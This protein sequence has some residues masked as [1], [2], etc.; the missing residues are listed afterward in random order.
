MTIFKNP[1]FLTCCILFWINQFLERVLEIYI[2][3]MHAY[4]DDLLAMP[5]V[6]GITL[7]V[8]RWIHPLKN[9]FRFTILQVV[10][11]WAYFSFLFEYVLPK[12]SEV[13]TTDILDVLCYAL[14]SWI[15][16]EFI[17]KK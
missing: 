7:Q 15:F 11:G 14:G 2:P 16:Y 6:L 3:Y 10:V 4:L 12:F 1:F 17:N 9:T 8:F 5:V 13:Y